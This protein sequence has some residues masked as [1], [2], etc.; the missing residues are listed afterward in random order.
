MNGGHSAP[1]AFDHLCNYSGRRKGR[2]D[3][4][5][6]KGTQGLQ[7]GMAVLAHRREVAAQ[8]TKRG[9]PWRTTKRARNL[10]LHFDHPNIPLGLVVGKGHGK[11]I[12]K[13]EDCRFLLR[14]AQEQILG[15]TVLAT[16]S[17]RRS[18][19]G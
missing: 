13:G 18:R 8:A 15:F 9:G 2:Q 19:R 11:V 12:H 5:S 16:T 7:Q 4:T 3:V 6:T 1:Y 14:Q 17:A 10:L